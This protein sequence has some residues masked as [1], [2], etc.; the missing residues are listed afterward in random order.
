M[1]DK[2]HVKRQNIIDAA[3]TL[4]YQRGYNQTSFTEIADA[5]GV[6]RGNF[7]YYFKSKDEILETV[8][9][10]RADRIK[11][12]IAEWDTV[13]K[14]PKAR[15]RR[16]VQMLTNSKSEVVRYGCPMGTLYSELGKTQLD[17]KTKAIEMLNIFR[18]WLK[19][20]FN[21]LG[22][23]EKAQALTLHILAWTQGVA[24]VAN[25]YSDKKLIT[26]EVDQLIEWVEDL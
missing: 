13:Y 26:A 14:D 9:N 22:H 16:Y 20:Q 5:A 23:K 4:F 10:N 3:N 11:E 7:Y 21:L 18:R 2:G 19:K 8:I 12:M 24:L 17:L 15:L 6:P 25:I 1:L